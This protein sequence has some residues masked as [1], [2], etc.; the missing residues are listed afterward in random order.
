MLVLQRRNVPPEPR[1]IAHE[2]VR[3]NL[4]QH[5]NARLVEQGG[6]AIDELDAERRLP[7]PDRAFQER[8]VAAR[9]P[10][11]QDGI[12]PAIPVLTKLGSGITV[13]FPSVACL[14]LGA[15]LRPA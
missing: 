15:G 12:E 1:R 8:D 14:T 11:R 3:R 7:A 5:D 4:E 9:D 10:L 6:A 13:F 2:F